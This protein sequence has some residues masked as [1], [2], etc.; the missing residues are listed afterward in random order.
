MANRAFYST[1]ILPVRMKYGCHA[2]RK[3]VVLL[4]L[5]FLKKNFHKKEEQPIEG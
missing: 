5:Q 1:T 4:P 2:E 3:K